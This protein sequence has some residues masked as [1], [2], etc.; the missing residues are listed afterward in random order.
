MLRLKRW[1]G[2]ALVVFIFY[3]TTV[4]AAHRHGRI[5]PTSGVDSVANPEHTSS[6]ASG[7]TSCGDCLICQL[8]QN[9]N[10]TL[11]AFRFVDPPVSVIPS[12]SAELPRD[13]FSEATG[14]IAGRAPPFLS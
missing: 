13:V 1:I 10:T 2:F 14:V 11:V 7:I 8:H 12:S 6:P 4:E 5:L 3:G 9:F